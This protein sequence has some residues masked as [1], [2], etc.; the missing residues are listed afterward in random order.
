M[1]EL[2]KEN[3]YNQVLELFEE[4]ALLDITRA[5]QGGILWRK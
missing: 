3:F 2:I 5:R 1:D 4:V